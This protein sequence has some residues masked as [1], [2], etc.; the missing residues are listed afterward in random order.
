MSTGLL[1]TA[2]PDPALTA[3]L[4]EIGCGDVATATLERAPALLVES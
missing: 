4:R 3:V 1:I 2:A